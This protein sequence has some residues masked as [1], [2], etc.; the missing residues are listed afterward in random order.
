MT[1]AFW[2]KTV[3]R[4]MFTINIKHHN[5]YTERQKHSYYLIYCRETCIIVT[6][7][8]SL[9]MGRWTGQFSSNNT[10][11]IYT[12]L[13]S[14]KTMSLTLMWFHAAFN[15]IS[16][17]VHIFTNTLQLYKVKQK[18]YGYKTWKEIRYYPLSYGVPVR[19]R[20]G[21]TLLPATRVQHDQ[22]CTQSH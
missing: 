16:I 1:V 2:N 6:W 7:D 13:Y 4:M 11:K 20:Y 22:N 12:L 19:E 17:H 15:I 3:R 5:Y 21:S 10:S 8:M 14:A 9:G 18:T